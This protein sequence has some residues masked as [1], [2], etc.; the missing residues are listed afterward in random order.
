MAHKTFYL[1]APTTPR[2][3]L[4][5]TARC[6]SPSLLP[7]LEQLAETGAAG[8]QQDPVRLHRVAAVAAEGDVQQLAVLAQL[9][10][11]GREPRALPLGIRTEATR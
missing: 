7:D 5:T 2:I 4:A 3:P 6:P 11:H 1:K 9:V 10:K 8:R